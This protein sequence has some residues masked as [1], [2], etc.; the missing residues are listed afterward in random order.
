M[1]II[2]AMAGRPGTGKSTIAR[3]LAAYCNGVVLDKDIIRRTL[4]PAGC[5]KSS[6]DEGS[7]CLSVMMETARYFFERE[8]KSSVLLD[9]CAFFLESEIDGVIDAA[10]RMGADC[11]F[12]ECV[13]PEAVA[14]NR[15]KRRSLDVL[16]PARTW[17]RLYDLLRRVDRSTRH[18]AA[19]RRRRYMIR[20]DCPIRE[21]IKAATEYLDDRLASNA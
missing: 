2:I 3:G 18:T 7:F 13:C 19:R 17:S 20:T 12:L 8:L 9:G 4:F 1:A 16:P 21:S 11:F 14:K 15:L 6:V 10:E 5:L